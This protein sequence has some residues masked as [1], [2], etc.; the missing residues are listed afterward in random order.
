MRRIPACALVM[1]L[2][3]LAVVAVAYA[4]GGPYDYAVG[5]SAPATV[6]A[7]EP[8]VVEVQVGLNADVVT[9]TPATALSLTWDVHVP[10]GVKTIGGAWRGHPFGTACNLGCPFDM[11]PGLISQPYD[12]DVVAAAPGTYTV[13]ADLAS[14]STPDVNP[15]DDSASTQI[16]VVPLKLHLASATAAKPRAG[17]R[18]T[19]TVAT[20]SAIS[21]H[22]VRVARATC[23]GRVGKKT[24]PGKPTIGVGKLMCAWVLPPHTGG[25]QLTVGAHVTLAAAT[26]SLSKKFRVGR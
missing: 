15:S 23:T 21:G 14:T 25:S 16:A 2:V 8:F 22:D 20:S 13:A 11:P 12:Y 3:T 6:G 17:R 26:A 4:D 19:W 18:F 10:A 24:L 5:V 1:A 7:G 9:T